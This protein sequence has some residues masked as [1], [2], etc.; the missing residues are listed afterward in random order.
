MMAGIIIQLVSMSVFAI[1][2]L[3]VIWNARAVPRN[4]KMKLLLATTS[5]S[6]ACIIIRN[7]YRAVE[8]SQ[9]WTGYLITHEVYF[10]V[11]DGALMVFAAVVFNVVHPAWCL[12]KATAAESAAE[13]ETEEKTIGESS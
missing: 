4:A 11:L 9:G 8:L 13:R 10:C 2:F 7:F 12:P 6:A 5:V 1:L 3:C